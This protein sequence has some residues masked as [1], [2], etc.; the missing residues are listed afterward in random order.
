[1]SWTGGAVREVLAKAGIVPTEQRAIEHG[2]QLVLPK[3]SLL[4]IYQTGKVVVQGK[5]GAEKTHVSQ[6]FGQA[7]PATAGY[8]KPAPTAP[9][10]VADGSR[11]REA[12]LHRVRHDSESTKDL[13][14]LLHRLRLDPIILANQPTSGKTIIEALIENS[15]VHYAI[16][17]LT[18]DDQGHARDRPGDI[19]YRARQNVVLELGMFLA[20]LGRQRVAILHKGDVELP[21][22]IHGLIY[23]PFKTK[24]SEAKNK[25]ASALQQAGFFISVDVLSAE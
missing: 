3:G 10:I 9:N 12:R 18:P 13:E 11:E 1:M 7:P 25:L 8:P 19:K 5:A 20:K 22:D 16:V 4:N 6:M 21:S 15:G 14:L 23:I 17:M 24:V 2:V